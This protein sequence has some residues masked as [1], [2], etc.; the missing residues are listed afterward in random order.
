MSLVPRRRRVRY[1][2]RAI[3]VGT[4]QRAELRT[5]RLRFEQLETKMT[6]S[7][8]MQ[9][10]AIDAPVD[11]STQLIAEFEAATAGDAS[12]AAVSSADVLRFSIR[13]CS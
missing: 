8:L 6:L 13:I 4:L 10:F 9:T 5:R 2:R 3:S 11:G 12:E 7:S 1:A